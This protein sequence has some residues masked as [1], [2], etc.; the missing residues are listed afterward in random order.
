MIMDVCNGKHFTACNLEMNC[1]VTI[2]KKIYFD[3]QYLD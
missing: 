3:F 2:K 1:G